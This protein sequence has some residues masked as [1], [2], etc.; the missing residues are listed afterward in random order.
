MTQSLTNND[1]GQRIKD[2]EQKLHQM[3]ISGSQYRHLVDSTSDFLYLVD[4]QGRYVFINDNHLQRL[5]LPAEEI[6][7]CSYDDFHTPQQS[8]DFAEKVKQVFTTGQSI[9]DEHHS[10]NRKEYFLRTFSPVRQKGDSQN[11]IAVA[12][13]SKDITDRKQTEEAL[14]RSEEKYRLLIENSNEAI[15]I[16]QKENIIFTNKRLPQM[17]GYNLPEIL[18]NSFLKLIL[19]EDRDMVCAQQQGSLQGEDSTNNY[20]FRI[21][22]KDGSTHWVQTNS[23]GINWD[24][25]PATL[26]FL[27]D[28]TS[29]KKTEAR[30]LQAKKMESIGT[31]A[32]GIAH[33]FNNLLMGIQGHA[34]LALLQIDP[35]DSIHGHL[36]TIETLVASGA[37]LTK[38]LLG[39]ARGGKYEVKTTDVNS[40][41]LR[42]SETI[43][44]T[45]KEI[46]IHHNLAADLWL[47]DVDSG[48][49]DQVLLNLYVNAWQAMPG[50][51]DLYLRTSNIILEEKMFKDY[52]GKN[53][54]YVKISITDTG[55][56]MDEKTKERIFEPFFTTKEMGRG[57]GLG[58]AS[59]YG[60]IKNHNGFINVYSEKGQGS[61]F[62]IYLPAS[63]NNEIKE[64]NTKQNT[65][66]T[67]GTETIL[68]VDDESLILDVA[69]DLL[70]ALGY[71]ILTAQN[72]IAAV[73]IYQQSKET[74]DLV[75]LD[76]VMPEMNGGEVFD[77]LKKINPDVKVLLSSGYSI[78]GQ[79]SK[80]I[81]RG[82]VGFIQKPFTMLEIARQLRNVLDDR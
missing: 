37:E 71:K 9:Q 24:N 70:K 67:R 26:N 43:G 55:V 29:Q 45:K 27:R 39:F 53:G 62:N 66:I 1:L 68:L 73:D 56:G 82:C 78:N 25:Q 44:R 4:E 63:P 61:T 6:I 16:I 10:P 5:N 2:L 3:E 14:K 8:K 79:A 31:L 19:E 50:G 11:N 54:R 57:A 32:G 80:I 21:I 7:G 18:N 75:I 12:I 30:L 76:M 52:D 36:K 58:L 49:I 17:L 48:Q 69:A 59:V 81:S 20:V 42:T 46:T 40:L 64:Q 77:E 60:I 72:G 22:N 34:S 65:E 33:D 23:V 15:F 47:T 38:Q 51:G 74:I 35:R 28:I 13:V 41:I